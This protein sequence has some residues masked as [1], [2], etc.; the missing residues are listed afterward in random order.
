MIRIATVEKG[1]DLRK[2]LPPRR[3]RQ[4]FAA[5]ERSSSLLSEGDDNDVHFNIDLSY[6][7]FPV[8]S[9]PE[10]LPN[11][12]EGSQ[13]SIFGPKLEEGIKPGTTS[14]IGGGVLWSARSSEN[15]DDNAELDL[16]VVTTTSVIVYNMNMTKK[17]LIKAH[18]LPHPLAAS[19]WFE[20][21]AKTLVIGSYKSNLRQTSTVEEG[22]GL[23]VSI[24]I[25]RNFSIDDNEEHNRQGDS[26]IKSVSFP[27]AVMSMKTI[28]F[29]KNSS[30]VQTL[31]TFVAGTLREI[32]TDDEDDRH[33]LQLSLESFGSSKTDNKPNKEKE[34][35]TVV[36]PTEIFLVRLY[37]D[38]YCI[39]LGSLG[40]DK[41]G[42]GL[43]K[44]DKEANCIHVRHQKLDALKGN[45]N[46][47]SISVG[48]MN[49]LLC[50]FSKNEETTY[51]IDVAAS[52]CDDTRVMRDMISLYEPTS[53][54][55]GNPHIHDDNL[56]FL[57]PHYFLDTNGQG[58]LF[59]VSLSLPQLLKGIPT[60]AMCIPFL[61]R[62][63][64]SKATIRSLI[65]ERFSQLIGL[66]DMSTL[67][68]W[69]TVIIDEYAECEI[70][71][72]FDV[73]GEAH[74][75]EMMKMAGKSSQNVSLLTK[76]SLLQ[77]DN[78]SNAEEIV[79]GSMLVPP[80]ACSHVL[81][82]AEVIQMILLPHV[83][84]AIQMGDSKKLKFMSSFAVSYFVELERR[85]L[86]PCTALQ[87]LV[88][89]LLWLTGQNNELC[90][91]LS[92]QQTQW[93][94][95]RRRRQLELPTSNRM[96]FDDPGAVSFAETLFQIATDCHDKGEIPVS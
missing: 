39:E 55:S 64:N 17:K 45:I 85:F 4:T 77:L 59:E 19:F 8:T 83:K 72:K 63:S 89:A 47:D 18:V 60:T 43:T 22:S 38:V 66:N 86:A 81:T 70:A 92:A 27:T 44:L 49:N 58:L 56:S 46:E 14:I 41:G 9:K 84:S 5:G 95:T 54:T 36:L 67:R 6:D 23:D 87:C 31:P 15:G 33:T 34:S 29:S 71:T 88:I 62:R 75:E 65:M 3:R 93:T 53:N 21:S 28:F 42:I 10:K 7:A 76:C 51:Y 12:R 91:F 69:L 2:K 74:M 68:T 48:V 11:F 52:F 79:F 96:H 16:I 26:S 90:A 24:T 37:D 61:L 82:Q 78:I 57:A 40:T 32:S 50:I 80:E 73:E 94:I 13:R 20:A 35:N 25:D 1:E 30:V